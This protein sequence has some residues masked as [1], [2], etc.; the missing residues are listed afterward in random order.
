VQKHLC[1]SGGTC[2]EV[3]LSEAL[4]ILENLI[5]FAGYGTRSVLCAILSS[6]YSSA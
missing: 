3:M 6:N 5:C 4:W 2:E 1:A